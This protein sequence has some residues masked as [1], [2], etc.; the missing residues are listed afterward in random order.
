MG[1][2]KVHADGYVSGDKTVDEEVKMGVEMD[3]VG[4]DEAN[5]AP[6]SDGVAGIEE[7]NGVNDDEYDDKR[8]D[9]YE[10]REDE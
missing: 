4:D 1:D 9:E 5:R 8:D 6:H 2:T 7:E 3:E 10:A